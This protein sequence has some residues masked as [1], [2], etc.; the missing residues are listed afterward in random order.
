M[1]ATKGGGTVDGYPNDTR[2]RSTSGSFLWSGTA[3]MFAEEGFRPIGDLGA[4]KRIMRKH[5]L[6]TVLAP[7]SDRFDLDPHTHPTPECAS[8]CRQQ[9]GRGEEARTLSRSG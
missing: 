2:G 8:I 1:I 9:P 4:S 7:E 6:R 5:V 3:S